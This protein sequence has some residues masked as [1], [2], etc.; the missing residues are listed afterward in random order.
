M[1]SMNDSGGRALFAA[2]LCMF[3]A[4]APGCGDAFG[5]AANNTQSGSQQEGECTQDTEGHEWCKTTYDSEAYFCG[6]DSECVESQNCQAND[7]CVPG[8]QG[9]TFCSATYGGQS[10]CEAAED[11]GYCS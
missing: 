10:I 7:C 1:P 2:L 3:L 11:N 8:E 5:D 9:N 4:V 6:L